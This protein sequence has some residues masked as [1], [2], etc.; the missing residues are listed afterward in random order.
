MDT[1]ATVGSQSAEYVPLY[2]H[3][4]YKQYSN[5]LTNSTPTKAFN[6]TQTPSSAIRCQ[7][8]LRAKRV[9]LSSA[10]ASM[11]EAPAKSSSLA[12]A[13]L[14]A[15]QTLSPPAP[16]VTS[17]TV[18]SLLPQ[19]VRRPLGMPS[20]HLNSPALRKQLLLDTRLCPRA[21]R[22]GPA[23]TLTVGLQFKLFKWFQL[24]AGFFL[25]SSGCALLFFI[26]KDL[27]LFHTLLWFSF[28]FF[29]DFLS[30]YGW[31]IY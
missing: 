3:I 1:S 2:L 15:P 9:N 27:V 29:F 31:V 21:M 19:M 23:G 28:V 8:A 20:R 10:T 18:F 14:S 12:S 7:T 22:T 30:F 4:P 16:T 11:L 13:A 6:M 25:V 24:L 5:K 26:W 17:I